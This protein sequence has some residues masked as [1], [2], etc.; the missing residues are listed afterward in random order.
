MLTIL[1][2]SYISVVIPHQDIVTQL[3]ADTLG[4]GACL[5][6]SGGSRFRCGTFA[7]VAEMEIKVSLERYRI[8]R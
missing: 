7:Q 1:I 5:S 8:I 6:V 2:S 4:T 3:A